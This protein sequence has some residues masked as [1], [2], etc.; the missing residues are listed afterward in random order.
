MPVECQVEFNPL[1]QEQFHDVDRVVM[2]QV[3]DIHNTLGRFC[4]EQAYQAEL[5]HRSRAAGLTVH[6]EVLLGPQH[7]DFAK[8][9]YLDL[10]I[11]RGVIYE[12][13]AVEALSPSHEKQL[14]NYLLLAGIHHGK[15]VNFG[16]GSVESR[17][18]STRLRFEDRTEI[19]W[20]DEEWS[21]DDQGS[22]QLRKDLAGLLADWG[23]FLDVS[24]Y[25]EAL[26]HFHNGP[27]AGVQAVEI[28]IGGRVIGTQKMCLLN[29]ST[30]WHLSA[31]R[32]HQPSYERHLLRLLRHTH[33]Q[34]LHWIN[35]HHHTVM[36]KT[37]SP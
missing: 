26:V 11:D 28:E 12:L 10:L 35:L 30:A 32:Q 18:V 20:N 24:L 16:S 2:R 13:K 17:F 29:Q 19:D 22:R 36:L 14:I 3:F 21:G 33:L 34:R 27:G 23:A 31:I 1:G 25:R 37:L 5:A 15:L 8:S 6:Q 9:Y 7:R 4:D